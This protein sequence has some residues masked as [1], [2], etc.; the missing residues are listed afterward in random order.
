MKIKAISAFIIC[1]LVIANFIFSGVSGV[2]LPNL[3][4]KYRIYLTDNSEVTYDMVIIT[5][6]KF[7]SALEP[8]K[9]HKTT[10]GIKTRLVSLE[11][12]F[13][14]FEGRDKQEQ[15]KYFIKYAI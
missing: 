4:E 7:S 5:P 6:K 14:I 2:K 12:I 8:L 11:T 1:F 15:I 3:M 13:D 9:D 10:Y